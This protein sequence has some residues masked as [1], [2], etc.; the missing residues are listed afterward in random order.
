[1]KKTNLLRVLAGLILALS[2]TGCP[3]PT[4]E[5]AKP[6]Q[7]VA[8]ENPLATDLIKLNLTGAKALGSVYNKGIGASR[9]ARAADDKASSDQLL[10][11]D[12]EG[13]AESVMENVYE[14]KKM[15]FSTFE[16]IMEIKKNP[17]SNIPDYSK[18]T[19]ITFENINWRLEYTDGTD[20]P[21]LGQLIYVKKS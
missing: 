8:P 1:M 6:Q 7:P 5:P 16:Q 4:D 13:N 19:Y 18:G 11:F 3:K 2:L 12:A 20:A 17:Y 9:S 10:K 21:L 14:D 15:N